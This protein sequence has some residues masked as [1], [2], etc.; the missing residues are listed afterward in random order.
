MNPLV[1]GHHGSSYNIYNLTCILSQNHQSGD[2]TRHTGMKNLSHYERVSTSSTLA[3]HKLLDKINKVDE[4]HKLL[5]F[6]CHGNQRKCAPALRKGN[7]CDESKRAFLEIDGRACVPKLSLALDFN[8]KQSGRL[9]RE[10]YLL[11]L[12]KTEQNQCTRSLK[13]WDYPKIISNFYQKTFSRI[14]E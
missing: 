6:L 3:C 5:H 11:F 10:A 4:F 9:L 2:W 14:L 12:Y 7:R 1:Q 8:H 13:K